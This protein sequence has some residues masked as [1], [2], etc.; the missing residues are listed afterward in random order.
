MQVI[1][2]D[3][4]KAQYQQIGLQAKNEGL[5]RD[6]LDNYVAR[7]WDFEGKSGS[8]DM[9]SK[10]KTSSRHSL[11][12]SLDTI[13]EGWAKGYKLKIEGASNNLAAL[14]QEI[15]NVVESRKLLDKGMALRVDTGEV[16]GEGKPVLKPFLTTHAEPGYKKIESPYFKKWEYAGK[17]EDYEQEE[18]Q[19]F[20][21]RR[22]IMV[23]PEGTVMKKSDVYTP[24]KVAKSLNNI[25]GKS[26]LSDVPVIKQITEF[27]RGV[28]LS[29]LSLSGF[30][31][32]AFSRVHFLMG[33]KGS[34]PHVNPITAYKGGLDLMSQQNP[35]LEMLIK[36]GMTISRKQDF[37]EGISNH[38]SWLDKKL[39][40]LGWPGEMKDKMKGLTEA[41]HKHLFETY[42]AGLKAFDGVNMLQKEIAAHPDEN[43]NE[44]AKRVAKMVNDSYG[45]INWERMHGTGMQNPTVR[46]LSSLLMLAPDWTAS[47]L[48]FAKKAFERGQE[49][50]LYRKAWGRVILR[51]AALTAV[52]NAGMAFMDERGDETWEQAFTRRYKQAWEQGNLKELMIDISP[53]YHAL[54]G[55]TDKRA[56]FSVFG[57]YTDPLKAVSHPL[58][59]LDNKMSYVFKVGEEALTSENW[60]KK[61]FTTLDELTGLDDKG[62]YT[63]K[64]TNKKTG[65]VFM[66]GMSKGGKMTGELTKWAQRGA[67]P[68]EYN[69]LPS[70]ILSQIR[71]ATP[72][73]IQNMWQAASGENDWT[74]SVLNAVGTGISAAKEKKEK[75]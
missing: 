73:S 69:Q 61:E 63:R 60:Q 49:G 18:A 15:A 3:D 31:Y 56:Y 71:G 10:L 25:L 19:L 5:I 46:H 40:Q 65:Q 23:T 59:Y 66:P 12:R 29:I 47:N 64:Y 68:L 41:M 34:F 53:L 22:D 37:D 57:A 52:A 6:V 24:D 13:L 36:N 26:A 50:D 62:V 70:F 72:V 48:R 11:E 21:R 43:P 39:D 14:K 32:V 7:F 75:D 55:E 42:G 1:S 38:I 51:G 8:T 30:H 20:G 67:H 45:G 9:F 35:H 44:I 4:I 16:D 33:Q 54:G 28:K 58:T 27:N 2:T 74:Y 17:L